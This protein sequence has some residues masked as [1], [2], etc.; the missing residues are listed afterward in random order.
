MLDVQT[1]TL[2]QLAEATGM[3]IRNIRSY[4]TRGLIP[5]PSRDGRRSVYGPQHLERLQQIHAARAQGATLTLIR[6]HLRSGGSLDASTP[7]ATVMPLRLDEP[8]AAGKRTVET[9]LRQRPEVSQA[10]AALQR[11]GVAI[12]ECLTVAHRAAVAAIGLREAVRHASGRAR[13][14]RFNGAADGADRGLNR[15]ALEVF[16]H[17]L[18]AA[19]GPNDQ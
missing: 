13:R 7:P 3:T 6:S 8:V 17:Y 12:E 18:T 2:E 14:G 15:L 5:R 9:Q 19:S 16:R 1:Y 4:Q 11:Q 10:I